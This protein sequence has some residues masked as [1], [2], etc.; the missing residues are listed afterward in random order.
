[1]SETDITLDR[2]CE[3]LNAVSVGCF[4]IDAEFKAACRHA[5]RIVRASSKLASA[6]GVEKTAAPSQT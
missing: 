1:M 4:T 2:L 6:L 3:I 5:S